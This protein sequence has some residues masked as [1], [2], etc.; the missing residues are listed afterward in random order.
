MRLLSSVAS[1]WIF[2][3]LLVE[4]CLVTH[5]MREG[6]FGP[7]VK[8]KVGWTMPPLGCRCICCGQTSPEGFKVFLTALSTT[9][10]LASFTGYNAGNC[11]IQTI[12]VFTR[13]W[14]LQKL[15]SPL[16]PYSTCACLVSRNL[17]CN[18]LLKL[19]CSDE[20]AKYSTVTIVECAYS[21]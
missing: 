12:F 8:Q 10:A 14:A 5:S 6:R 11:N 17:G 16:K 4:T 2:C 7:W 9:P 15:Q 21:I 3:I 13:Q 1:P 18:Q 20:K 19:R